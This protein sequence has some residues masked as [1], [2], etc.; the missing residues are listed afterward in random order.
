M[1]LTIKDIA[2][3]CGVGKST[4][5][6]V[7]NQDPHVKA[8]TRLRVQ[9]VIDELGFQPNRVAR[10]MRG[11]SETVVGIICTRLNSSAESQ[12][13][14]AIL[15]ALY[16]QNITPMIVESQFQ[17]ELVAKQLQLF[18]KRQVSG[19]ILFAFSELTAEL[20]QSWQKPLVSLVRA[21]PNVSS[22]YYDDENAVQTLLNR[23]Y[24]DGHRHI[25]YLGVSDE[26]ETTG[27]KRNQSYL[28]FCQAHQLEPH[29]AYAELN[30]DSGYQQTKALFKPPLTALL[31]ASTSLAAGALKFWQ[32]T[33]QNSPLACIGN[34]EWLQTFAPEL[35][36]LDFGYRQAGKSAV[37]LLL[38]QLN[39]DLTIQQQ[40]IPFQL[41]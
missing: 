1:A 27:R 24:A 28:A 35:I 20:L 6:R 13:L 41:S 34:N 29:I 22:V 37:A 3:R 23:L 33:G 18:A 7:L 25:G 5:S 40:K 16:A 10:A 8:E 9:K 32:E 31:C 30:I 14:S 11:E 4:V 21:Y 2:A 39:G 19:V 12:T 15:K 26:D 17:P 36:S 38:N